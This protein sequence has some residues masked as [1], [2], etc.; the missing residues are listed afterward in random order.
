[1]S[2]DLPKHMNEG[3]ERLKERQALGRQGSALEIA[4]TIVFLLSEESSF[5]SGAV[6]VA[7][8]GQVC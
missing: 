6:L 8:G 3:L 5:V 2:V 4:N 1:M 7:D